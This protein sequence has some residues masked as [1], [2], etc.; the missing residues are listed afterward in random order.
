MKRVCFVTELLF[1]ET[2]N[3]KQIRELL[4]QLM[5]EGP[6]ECWFYKCCRPFAVQALETIMEI[7]KERPDA[8]LAV[9]DVV[10]PLETETENMVWSEQE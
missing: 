1:A 2:R 8:E 4:D 9:V 10:D 3:L 5:A 7:R 6:V